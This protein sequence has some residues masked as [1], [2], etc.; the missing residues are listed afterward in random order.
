MLGARAR[1]VSFPHPRPFAIRV[2]PH[3][4]ALM[5]PSFHRIIVAQF[6]SALADNALLI[7]AIALLSAQGRP[8]W[9]AP[10]LKFGFIMPMCCWRPSSARWPTRCQG[11]ADGVDER[12]QVA[13]CRGCCC[14]AC[15]R[16]WRSCVIGLGAAAMRRPSTAWSPSSCRRARLV[17]ANGWIEV[18]VV[19][20]VLL[21]TVLRRLSGQPVVRA[22]FARRSAAGR[23]GG[24]ALDACRCCCCWACTRSQR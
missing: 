23:C 2:C 8:A 13:R 10:L 9:W 5:P 24:R 6:T 14:S 16:C 20:A 21:G 22:L 17:A 11:A 18:T 19:G 15:I 7:V 3:G 4:L 1:T 12:R